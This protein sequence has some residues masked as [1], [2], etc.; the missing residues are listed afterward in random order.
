VFPK[1]S[2]EGKKPFLFVQ[3]QEIHGGAKREKSKDGETPVAC[4]TPS[5][6]VLGELD[7]NHRVGRNNYTQKNKT[8]H[9]TDR[10]AILSDKLC[11][12]WLRN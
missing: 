10:K 9:R 6:G 11:S 5:A 7:A 1:A 2:C 12:E 3:A 8:L 4:E